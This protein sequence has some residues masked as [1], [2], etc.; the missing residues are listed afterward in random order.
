MSPSAASLFSDSVTVT[1]I[2][3]GTAINVGTEVVALQG[4]G[5]DSALDIAPD[6]IDF[7]DVEVFTTSSTVSVSVVNVGTE[8]VNIFAAILDNEA[9]F[10]IVSES[11]SALS[12]LEPLGLAC[13]YE[14]AAT[15][16]AEGAV[17]GELAIYTSDAPLPTIIDLEANGTPAAAAVISVEPT[18]IDMGDIAVFIG[19]LTAPGIATVTVTNSGASADLIVTGITF[20]GY[21]AAQFSA[22]SAPLPITIVPG[23]SQ[24]IGVNLVA[25]GIGVRATTMT[26]ESNAGP[27][28]VTITAVSQVGYPNSITFG[29][30]PN[31]LGADVV[32]M[33]GDE[34][35]VVPGIAVPFFI[36]QVTALSAFLIPSDNFIWIEGPAFLQYLDNTGVWQAAASEDDIQS[37]SI[38]ATLALIGGGAIPAP[39]PVGEGLYTLHVGFDL[40]R[41]NMI[42]EYDVHYV[43]SSRSIVFGP[44]PSV[45]V[46][47]T[48]LIVGDPAP[49]FVGLNILA[50]T[51]TTSVDVYILAEDPSGT[52]RWWNG[53]TWA[54]GVPGVYAGSV[55]VD[56]LPS[57]F[58]FVPAGLT[59]VGYPTINTLEGVHTITIVYDRSTDGV[60]NDTLF[61]AS[62]TIEV[63]PVP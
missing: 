9:D 25:T 2:L 15:P 53:V 32:F 61:S 60:F 41:D 33:P 45:F 21:D 36:Q 52:D 57:P 27:E 42:S 31:G 58:A 40:V 5:T 54:T 1:G 16:Q 22:V 18:T 14:V 24:V 62:E 46:D 56:V 26:I 44:K 34:V 6:A 50:G 55:G 28:E 12:P 7:G 39:A 19:S 49:N 35:Y 47:D 51:S 63:L 59:W 13:F 20:D 10:E 30:D 3:D 8:P 48:S 43:D 17:T 38:G 29:I 37:V 11:C 4:R 23:A